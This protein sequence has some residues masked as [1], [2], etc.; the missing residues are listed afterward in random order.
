VKLEALLQ[1]ID[2]TL[3]PN[4]FIA[5]V[6]GRVI[7]VGLTAPQALRAAK[8]TRPKDKPLILFVDADGMV[9]E[10]N[11][12]HILFEHGSASRPMKFKLDA[13][14]ASNYPPL[15]DVIKV[16]QAQQVGAYLVGGPVRDLLLGRENI[17]DLDFVV[18]KDGIEVARQVADA[19]GVAFYPLDK[20]RG[21][22]RVICE[23]KAGQGQKKIYLDFATLRGTTLPAD[24]KDRDFTINAMALS[25]TDPPKLIDPFQGQQDMGLGQIKVVTPTAFQHD[26]VRVLR[27]VRQANE[28]GFSIE[29]ETQQHLRQAAS[30]LSAISPE[31]QRDELLKSLNTPSPGQAIQMLHRLEVLPHLLPE[32]E[33]TVGVAQSSPHHLDVFDHTATALEAWAKML[34]AGLPDVFAKFQSDVEQYLTQ[35]LAGEVTLQQLMPL[36]LLWHDAGKPLTRTENRTGDAVQI[37]FL[38]HA[39]V[40]AAI[41]RQSMTAFHFSNQA[42]EFVENVIIHHMRPLLLAKEGGKISRRAIYRFFRDTS[43]KGYQAGVAVALHALADHQATYP[44]ESAHEQVEKQALLDLVNTLIASY[45][46]QRNGVIAPPPLLT[47][48]ELID[49]LGLR[50]G[51]LIGLLLNRLREAQATGQVRDRAEA[52]AFIEND[53]DFIKDRSESGLDA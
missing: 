47:G 40:S 27:A 53:P 31:R 32:I 49:T 46:E 26:P 6:R 50:E 48:R 5:I 36:A 8:Q 12:E 10:M 18:P 13:D 45:F 33:A 41:A 30:S 43:E 19:I 42:V 34:Q 9:K 14:W 1:N 24:L 21:V 38:G 37:H 35:E 7:G 15:E 17:V 11:S 3:Y 20:D 52:L 29:V 51:Q 23:S 25:L 16:L 22:G 28:F 2:T 39:R 4:R 44:A